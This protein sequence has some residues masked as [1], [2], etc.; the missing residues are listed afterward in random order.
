MITIKR[1]GT[2]EKDFQQLVKEL[3]VDLTARYT[4]YEA[5]FL[6][7]NVLSDNVSVVLIWYNNELAGCGALRP[8]PEYEAMELKRM[9][10]RPPYRGKGLSKKVLAELE[11]WA[12]E[13]GHSRILLETGKNQPEA[14]SLYLKNG[15]AHITSFG[16]YKKIAEAICM[17][18]TLSSVTKI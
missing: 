5:R 2:G 15:Y 18:K 6:D 17:E 12:I 4:N 7:L 8:L 3:D 9:Y 14:I 13:M 11:A 1:T 10:I 16:G